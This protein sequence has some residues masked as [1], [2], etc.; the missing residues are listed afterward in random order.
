MR[1]G[2]NT[3]Q[4]PGKSI[5]NMLDPAKTSKTQKIQWKR[6]ILKENKCAFFSLESLKL[7]EGVDAKHTINFKRPNIDRLEL[8]H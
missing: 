4:T 7:N 1:E 6:N 8:C 2:E 3:A 5:F